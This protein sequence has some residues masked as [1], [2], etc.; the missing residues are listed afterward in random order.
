LAPLV[1][2]GGVTPCWVTGSGLAV[3][4]RLGA[5]ASRGWTDCLRGTWTDPSAGEMAAAAEMSSERGGVAVSAFGVDADDDG[6]LDWPAILRIEIE[7]F[8]DRL[9]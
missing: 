4:F 5:P 8:L 3:A 1:V 9:G 2:S 6:W 7:G